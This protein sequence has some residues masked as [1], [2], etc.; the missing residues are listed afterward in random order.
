MNKIRPP[1]MQHRYL[2]P[3]LPAAGRQLCGNQTDGS[4]YPFDVFLPVEFRQT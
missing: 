4:A 2:E 3:K 1:V